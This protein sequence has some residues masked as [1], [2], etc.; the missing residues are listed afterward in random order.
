V[1]D[2]GSFLTVAAA[3]LVSTAVVVGLF[4]LGTRLLAAAGRMLL[5]EPVEFTDAITVVT[6]AEAAAAA[7][8]A[9]KAEK[10][11]PLSAT[12]K[13]LALVGAYACFTLCAAAVVYCIYLI[14]PIF[15]A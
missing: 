2:W 8:R 3:S 7:K 15:H 12:R 4:S 5:V 14:I 11:N 6:P 9:R 10:K 13:R 1:I